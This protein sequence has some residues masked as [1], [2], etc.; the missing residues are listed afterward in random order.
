MVYEFT[1]QRRINFVETDMAGIMHFSNFFR[2]M[3]EVEHD[4]F[5]S[6]GLGSYLVNKKDATGWPKVHASCDYAKPIKFQET[7]KVHLIIERIGKSSITYKYNFYNDNGECIARG[8]I[9]TVHSKKDLSLDTFSSCKIPDEVLKK[10]CEA[11]K[12]IT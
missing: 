7:I 9:I 4:F 3:E 6:L 2:I 12:N 1:T 10:I 5:S 8:K 11:P